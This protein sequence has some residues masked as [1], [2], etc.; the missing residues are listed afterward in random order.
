MLTDDVR[1][2]TA[3]T[4]KLGQALIA[5]GIL[6]FVGGILKIYL[7]PRLY[8]SQV[9]YFASSYDT[10]V[11]S[12]KYPLSIL[13]GDRDRFESAV[14]DAFTSMAKTTNKDSGDFSVSL[15]TVQKRMRHNKLSGAQPHW[16]ATLEFPNHELAADLHNDAFRRLLNKDGKTISIG[17]TNYTV[18]NWAVPLG[19]PNPPPP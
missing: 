7:T 14:E 13:E 3:T 4:S 19:V 11:R 1:R 2:K 15:P 18:K 6:I 17:N 9:L 16:V 8:P 5:I 12:S 10:N